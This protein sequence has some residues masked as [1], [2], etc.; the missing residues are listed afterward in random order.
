MDDIV[1]IHSNGQPAPAYPVSLPGTGTHSV[2]YMPT[3]VEPS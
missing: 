2:L 3:N 1:C